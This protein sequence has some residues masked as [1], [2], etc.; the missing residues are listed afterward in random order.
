MVG[1]SK[2]LTVSYGTFS[3]TLEGFDDSF[4]TMKAIAEYFRDLAADDRY[5]GAEPPTPDAEMLQKI[6]EREIHKRVEARVT[7]NG[8]AL[9]ADEEEKVPSL[10]AETPAEAAPTPAP[11]PADKAPAA[12]APQT[13]ET[14]ADYT[15]DAD[16]GSV[17]AKLA[18][19]RA[20]VNARATAPETIEDAQIIDES[21]PEAPMS[22]EEMDAAP[23]AEEQDDQEEDIPAFEPAAFEPAIEEFDEALEQE[24]EE[25]AAPEPALEP[26]LEE[27]DGADDDIIGS[28]LQAL[29]SARA[30]I[31]DDID[32]TEEVQ[33]DDLATE[34]EA[35]IFAEA[36]EEA[37][38]E[39]AA[40]AD[41]PEFSGMPDLAMPVEEDEGEDSE[42]GI[43]AYESEGEAPEAEER[44]VALDETE[45][46]ESPISLDEVEAEDVAEEDDAIAASEDALSGAEVDEQPVNRAQM[47]I[48]RA[49]ARVMKVKK[50]DLGL[51][52]EQPEAQPAEPLSTPA[53]R[54]RVVKP[55][56]VTRTD[57]STPRPG[58]QDEA[59]ESPAEEIQAR[60]EQAQSDA[61]V[62][63]DEA[64]NDPIAPQADSDEPAVKEMQDDS[65]YDE[66]ELDASAETEPE[67]AV[68][69]VAAAEEDEDSDAPEETAYGEADDEDAPARASDADTEIES[70]AEAEGEEAE[71]EAKTE[72]SAD[73]SDKREASAQDEIDPSDEDEFIE[74]AE[75]AA[76]DSAP[77][78]TAEEGSATLSD[79]E[80]AELMA[81]LAAASLAPVS[82]DDEPPLGLTPA[83]SLDDAA[84]HP[85][86]NVSRLVDEVNTKMDQPE[87][88]RRRS[89]IAHLKAAVAATMADRLLGGRRKESEAEQQQPYRKDL[90]DVV[91]PKAAAA[92]VDRKMP[93]LMLV[94]EQRID[95]P[96]LTQGSGPMSLGNLA[97]KH[98]PEELLEEPNTE[99]AEEGNIFS[100]EISFAEFAEQNGATDLPDVMEAAAA[101]FIKVENQPHFTRPRVMRASAEVIGQDDFIRED[102][103][104]AFGS[105]LRSGV[106]ERK[107]RGQFT[108]REE[109]RFMKDA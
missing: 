3:C 11:A 49:R 14:T 5:F 36:E 20:A 93:P 48:A 52:P 72:T 34:P 69:P 100:D 67:D 77:E 7:D 105:L 58:E 41:I 98:D 26:E 86:E 94:S 9:R 70:E 24:E 37:E 15:S 85:E 39:E 53:T 54:A 62:A 57:I 32:S 64:L 71:L 43:A 27:E 99:E 102:G 45:A 18:R 106:F 33:D 96:G 108:I 92:P 104:R 83:R 63:L 75:A 68:E 35:D 38:P 91:R 74:D 88:T 4:D 42:G 10:A 80:E 78:V 28:A 84:E 13:P 76:K 60:D 47:A 101:Y 73:D 87:N 23:V 95:A 21:V 29:T 59:A 22:F 65:A 16:L 25:L 79:E 1:A 46:E 40:Q 103:L 90:D 50:S 61:E 19:I 109:S 81:E 107:Q 17:A 66:D 44:L 31:Q 89:A 6:A 55:R 51:R 56:R 82:D 12:A 97:V 8:I 30:N 2:I